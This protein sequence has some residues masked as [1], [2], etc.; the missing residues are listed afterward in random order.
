MNLE[1]NALMT[2]NQITIRRKLDYRSLLS[3]MGALIGNEDTIFESD[4]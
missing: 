2:Q 4:L 1:A 3:G